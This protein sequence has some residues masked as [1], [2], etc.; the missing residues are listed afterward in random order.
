[1]CHVLII[2]DEPMIAM[3]VRDTLEE[4]GATSFA[5]A[6]TQADAVAA[7]NDRLP[8]MITSDVKLLEGSGPR[9]VALIHLEI[10]QIPVL[11]ITGTPEDCE[12]CPAPAQILSKPFSS[13][14][15]AQLFQ[16]LTGI[17]PPVR[18]DDQTI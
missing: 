13:D 1:M 11:F 5:F 15:L 16:E 6:A 7:A 12:P 17:S 14:R 8:A 18:P 3:L 10:G 9:A 4:A 2:E